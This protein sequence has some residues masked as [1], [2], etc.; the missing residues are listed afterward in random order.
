MVTGEERVIDVDYP[1]DH[2]NEDLAG[3]VAQVRVVVKEIKLKCMPDLDDEFASEVA[4]VGGVEELRDRVREAAESEKNTRAEQEFNDRVIDA[5]L[6]G[7]PFEVPEIL[8]RDQQKLSMDRM[9]QDLE[10][11]GIDPAA[12][13]FEEPRVQEAHQRAAERSVRWAFL[14]RAIAESEEIEVTDQEVD[15]RI[16]AIAQA[17]GRP[18]RVVRSF[19]ETEDRIDSLRSSILDRKVIDRVVASATV[20]EVEAKA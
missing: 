6:E 10:K 13:G 1:E 11:R 15:E 8:V 7:N 14:M 19:F 17:D 9:R 5:L 20:E 16:E 18:V 12:A 3:R 4:G 2:E